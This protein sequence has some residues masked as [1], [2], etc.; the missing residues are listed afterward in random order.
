M[1]RVQDVTGKD[2]TVAVCS[3]HKKR[4]YHLPLEY[5]SSEIDTNK[6]IDFIVYGYIDRQ[7]STIFSVFSLYHRS[8]RKNQ[9]SLLKQ[10]NELEPSGLTSSHQIS[11]HYSVEV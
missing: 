5:T 4:C 2:T 1:C 8:H 3:E 9:L 11:I 7:F 6:V 10:I